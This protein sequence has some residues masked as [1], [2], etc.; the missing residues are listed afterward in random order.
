M[1]TKCVPWGMAAVLKTL[2]SQTREVPSGCAGGMDELG[3][4]GW[5][6]KDPV[7]PN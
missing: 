1:L 2:C 3:V 7:L 6:A 4:F 5:S